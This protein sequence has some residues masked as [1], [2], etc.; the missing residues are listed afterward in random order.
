M[1]TS[2]AGKT[3]DQII[4]NTPLP[5]GDLIVSKLFVCLYVCPANWTKKRTNNRQ[6]RYC[7]YSAEVSKLY[8]YKR[9]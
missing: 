2:K 9:R 7:S 6:S 5:R 1:K 4:E 8:S 3:D